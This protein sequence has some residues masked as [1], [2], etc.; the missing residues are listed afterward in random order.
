[1]QATT[2]FDATRELVPIARGVWAVN[3][4][5]VNPSLGVRNV[6]E[7]IA[8]AKREPGALAFGTP[9][10]AAAPYLGARMIQELAG[11]D[12]L[13]VPY[14][15]VG[16]AYQDLVGGRLQ[17]MYT[18]LASVLPLIQ[19]GKV[20]ALA[21]DRPSALLP[22]VPTFAESGLRFEAPTSFS[23]MA[24]AGIS[25]ELQ[26]RIG[27]QVVAALKSITPRLEQQ[28]LTPVYDTPA[29]FAE[30]IRAERAMW[31]EFVRRNHIT[32]EQQ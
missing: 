31:A 20:D 24:P 21:I 3:V 32:A 14:K 10:M 13:H 23:I 26:G 1:M 8:K 2:N 17:F 9:G 16:P 29:K 4:L 18:D 27:S 5:V 22:G 15:G 30:D 7:F 6:A 25:P 28:A 12:V 19:S 11:L